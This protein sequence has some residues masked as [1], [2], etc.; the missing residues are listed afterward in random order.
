MIDFR[1]NVTYKRS[2]VPL[3]FW[4]NGLKFDVNNKMFEIEVSLNLYN[5]YVINCCNVIIFN[6]RILGFQLKFKP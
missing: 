3:S 5:M 1:E 6:S 4:F 2:Y